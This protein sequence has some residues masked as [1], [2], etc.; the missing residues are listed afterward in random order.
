MLWNIRLFSCFSTE[1]KYLHVTEVN[2]FQRAPLPLCIHGG[3]HARIPLVSIKISYATGDTSCWIQV[4]TFSGRDDATFFPVAQR[5]RIF[6]QQPAII[7]YP[8]ARVRTYVCVCVFVCAW[9]SDECVNEH[10]FHLC[11]C[12]CWRAI[13]TRTRRRSRSSTRP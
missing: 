1:R 12:S 8:H 10:A 9:G 13:T 4:A 3:R 7:F 6:A 2:Y 5:A 11:R